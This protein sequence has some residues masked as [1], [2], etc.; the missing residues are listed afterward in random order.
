[1]TSS[2]CST[3]LHGRKRKMT[4]NL[5]CHVDEELLDIYTDRSLPVTS[6][7][8][9]SH[10]V[11]QSRTQSLPVTPSHFSSHSQSLPVT[12]PVT[13]SHSRND[14]KNQP[15]VL[16]PTVYP[17]PHVFY[18][19]HNCTEDHG[20]CIVRCAR[21]ALSLFSRWKSNSLV[22]SFTTLLLHKVDLLFFF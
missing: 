9:Q 22:C 7:C 21:A 5:V 12:F 19:F 16:F 8:F 10:P 3:S 14:K 15:D 4:Q 17:P 13:L 20:H 18:A 1:M 2:H 6:S 11:T